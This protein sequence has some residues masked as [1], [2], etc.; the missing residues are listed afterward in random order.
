MA[1]SINKVI[2]LGNLGKEPEVRNTSTG[3]KIAT[4]SV[5]TSDVWK[6]KSG[7][8][9]EKTE[10]HRVVIFNNA[11]ADFAEKYMKKGSKVYIEGALQTRKWTD[12][13]GQDKYSTEI[14]I[15]NYRGELI[16]LDSRSSNGMGSSDSSSGWDAPSAEEPSSFDD[17]IPF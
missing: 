9:Q 4:L 13:N 3:Q 10:W 12:Q 6:D 1:G 17:D 16:S 15:G 11:L 5:A 8:K 2:L 14:I 7:Q